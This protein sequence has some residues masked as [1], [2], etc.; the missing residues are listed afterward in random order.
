MV[1]WL[2]IVYLSKKDKDKQEKD[3]KFQ[4]CDDVR[5]LL[6]NLIVLLELLSIII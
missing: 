3:T 5:D 4:G 2:I 6:L 1:G